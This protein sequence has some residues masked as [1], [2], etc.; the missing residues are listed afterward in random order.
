MS[1]AV[2]LASLM[3]FASS[4]ITSLEKSLQTGSESVPQITELCGHTP[5]KVVLCILRC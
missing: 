1:C 4:S 2:A 3:L 5:F